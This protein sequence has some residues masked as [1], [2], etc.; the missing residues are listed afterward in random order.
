MKLTSYGLAHLK[1]EGKRLKVGS[2]YWVI[3]VLDVDSSEEWEDCAQPAR[4]VGDDKWHCLNIEGVSDWPMR[5]V[6]SEITDETVK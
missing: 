1:G 4:Y 6:G 3:P 2:F 5:W